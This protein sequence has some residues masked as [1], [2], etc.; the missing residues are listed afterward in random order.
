MLC[1][2]SLFSYAIESVY[3]QGFYPPNF[4]HYDPANVTGINQKVRLN[5]SPFLKI[6]I[7]TPN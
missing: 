2:W 7:G 6:G 5:V 3:W 4:A 1:I